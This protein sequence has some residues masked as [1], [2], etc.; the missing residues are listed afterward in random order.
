NASGTYTVTEVRNGCTNQATTSVT[1]NPSSVGGTATA[2]PNPI[3]YN[4]STTVTLAGNTGSIQWQIS[5]DN[6][7]FTDISGQTGQTLTTG[8]LTATTYYRAK[9]TSGVCASA[10]STVATVTIESTPPTITSC[11]TNQTANANGSCQA[12]VP[13]FTTGT[14]ATDN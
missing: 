1:V 14:L 13:D 3:C 11:A 5:T 9:V 8:N 4:T 10:F 12:A 2:S 6:V 7:T